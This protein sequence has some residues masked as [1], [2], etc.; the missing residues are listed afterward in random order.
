MRTAIVYL[1]TSITLAI[2]LTLARRQHHE[3]L[4]G[5]DVYRY[6]PLLVQL[7]ALLT[8]VYGA[9]AAFVYSRDPQVPRTTGFIVALAVVFGAFIVGNTAAYFHFRSFSI[10]ITDS[11]IAVRSWGRRRLIRYDEIAAISITT[12]WRG[13]GEMQLYGQANKLIFKIANSIQDYDDLVWS[14]K[15]NARG[16]GVVVRERDR[17]GKWSE[18]INR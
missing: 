3:S 11:H 13:G 4:S 8:P 10:E 7:V 14:A 2:I 1:A 18:T 16:R 17:Y 9:A 5:T 6:P 15:N 12:G